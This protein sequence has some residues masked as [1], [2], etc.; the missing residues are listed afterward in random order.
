MERLR[1]AVPPQIGF[2]RAGQRL[3]GGTRSVVAEGDYGY[4][5][6]IAN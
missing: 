5:E 4:E 3:S 2:I 1:C 6:S